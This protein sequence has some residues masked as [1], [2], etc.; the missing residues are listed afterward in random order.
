CVETMVDIE[1]IAVENQ[2]FVRISPNPVREKAT[3]EYQI[4]KDGILK[5][6]DYQGREV[7]FYALLTKERKFLF[8]VESWT[9][10]IYLYSVEMEGK[11]LSSGK[12]VVD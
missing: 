9:S 2:V 1:D 5:V 4:P 8:E 10:G 12:L 11:R 6:Y 7:Q 3:I